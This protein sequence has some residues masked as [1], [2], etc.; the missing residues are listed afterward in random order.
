VVEKLEGKK[1]VLLN[2]KI[3]TFVGYCTLAQCDEGG[4]FFFVHAADSGSFV[5]VRVY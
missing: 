3:W 4:G 1:R 5:V 2:K